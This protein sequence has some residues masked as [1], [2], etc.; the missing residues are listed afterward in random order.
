V[1]DFWC[2]GDIRETQVR[3]RALLTRLRADAATAEARFYPG[4]LRQAYWRGV[5]PGPGWRM[6]AEVTA[7]KRN[8]P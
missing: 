4:R 7:R 8:T 2:D 1:N 3:L 6:P 5:R